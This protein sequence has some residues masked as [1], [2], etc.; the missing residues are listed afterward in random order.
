M[1]SVITNEIRNLNQSLK[2]PRAAYGLCVKA[3]AP[4]ISTIQHFLTTTG[5]TN[6]PLVKAKEDPAEA[7]GFEE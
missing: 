2:P 4:E 1:S 3:Q 5:A 7:S 6:A